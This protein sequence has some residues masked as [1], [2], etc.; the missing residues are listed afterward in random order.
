MAVSVSEIVLALRKFQIKVQYLQCLHWEYLCGVFSLEK[1]EQCIPNP[2]E[3]LGQVI[4]FSCVSI[5]I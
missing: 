1:P 3:D 4:N 5:A 2:E